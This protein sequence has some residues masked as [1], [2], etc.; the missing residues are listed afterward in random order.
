MLPQARGQRDAELAGSRGHRRKESI[1]NENQS[2]LL[3]SSNALCLKVEE[4]PIGLLKMNARN[5]R[6]HPEKQIVMLARNID[7]YGFLFPC[8]V[9]EHGRLLAGTARVLAAERLGMTAIPVVRVSHL[10]EADKR[11]V[12]IAD[13]KLAEM[14]DWDP[15]ILRNE[16][17]FFSNLDINFDFSV[18]GFETAEVDLLLESKIGD[19]DPIGATA[20]PQAVTGP[21][22]MWL[23]D[24]HRIYCGDALVATSYRGLLPHTRRCWT[25]STP[26]WSLQTRHTTFGSTVMSAALEVSSIGNL[27]WRRG[28]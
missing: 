1:V 11:A 25:V 15:E 16:L 21:G 9:D 7:T 24:R 26:N 18:L 8:L 2:S 4:L 28:R 5:P 22:D 20:G 13:N 23:A 27:R 14:S 19:D 3:G 6:K 12:V 17:Q 10:S